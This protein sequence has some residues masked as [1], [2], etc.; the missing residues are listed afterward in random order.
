MAGA[1][2]SL[3]F[4]VALWLWTGAL[5][6]VGLPVLLLPRRTVVG[7][8]RFWMAGVQGLLRTLVGLS[9]EVRGR[10]HLP[11]TPVILALKHQS[12]WETLVMFLVLEDAA[13]AL[14]RELALIPLFG[15]YTQRAGMLRIDRGSGA[16]AL[17][18][19]VDSARAALE[20]GSFVIIFP[21][22]T[23]VPPGDR[24]PYQPGVAAL[25]LQLRCP[26]VPVALNSGV[27]WGRRSFVK[28]PGTIVLEFLPPIEPGLGRR[29]FMEELERRLEGA[30]DRLAQEGRGQLAA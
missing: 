9:Y 24:R 13:I 28:Q 21:E 19:L 8:A 30:S 18:S 6:V 27:F 1:V 15:W 2:R 23:R 25:Y 16:R 20:R 22:G 11:A 12:A 4:N 7:Y 14:K 10:E 17:R 5:A 3:A 26:V 29:S